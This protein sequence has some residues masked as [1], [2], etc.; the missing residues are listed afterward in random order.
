MV[1]CEHCGRRFSGGDRLA[2]HHRSC[3]AEKPAAAVPG[4]AAKSVASHAA[5]P[6]VRPSSSGFGGGSFMTSLAGGK[7][8]SRAQAQPPRLLMC[9]ICG[10]EFGS[11][12]LGIHEPQCLDKWRAEQ[13]LLPLGQRARHEPVRVKADGGDG[14]VEAANDAARESLQANMVGCEHCGRRFSGGDRLAVHHRSCSA[15]KPAAAVPGFVVS[16][17]LGPV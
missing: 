14:G 13:L 10:R 12:S 6:S 4:F 5:G 1:G 16:A 7:A 3:S 11:Q 15:E 17:Y 2:V 9:Y 8:E